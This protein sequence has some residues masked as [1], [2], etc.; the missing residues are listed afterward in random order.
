MLCILCL[1]QW[2]SS[3]FPTPKCNTLPGTDLD[4]AHFS[5]N[6][7]LIDIFVC[8]YVDMLGDTF[9]KSFLDHI[10]AQ[11]QSLTEKE[12]STS[13][14]RVAFNVQVF[15]PTQLFFLFCAVDTPNLS[16]YIVFRVKEHI[17]NFQ[18]LEQYVFHLV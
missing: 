8:S 16:K 6:A 17:G 9:Q 5:L 3:A 4:L 1:I 18:S 15:N 12:M 14:R 11:F 2:W 13:N 10:P 7:K